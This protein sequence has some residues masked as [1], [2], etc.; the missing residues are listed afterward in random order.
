MESEWN[1]FTLIKQDY[2]AYQHAQDTP[3]D[4]SLPLNDIY[5]FCTEHKQ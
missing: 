4:F 5:I 1:V 2:L 3:D